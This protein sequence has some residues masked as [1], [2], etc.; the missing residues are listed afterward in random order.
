MQKRQK[1]TEKTF[2][3]FEKSTSINVHAFVTKDTFLDGESVFL[4]EKVFQKLLTNSPP[5]RRLNSHLSVS[6]TGYLIPAGYLC[7]S[8]P[9]ENDFWTCRFCIYAS[10]FSR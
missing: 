8:V 9:E 3:H 2:V 4:D 5:L 1:S 7:F 10:P 6:G